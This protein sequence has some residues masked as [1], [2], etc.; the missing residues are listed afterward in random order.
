MG[1]LISD[2]KA[3]DVT[4]PAG[5]YSFGDLFRINGWTGI[6]MKS[7]AAADTDRKLAL[8]VSSER[9]WKVKIPAIAPAVGA[10]LYWTAGAGVKRGDTDLTLT[11]T[12]VPVAKCVEAINANGYA[13]VRV[14]QGV[15]V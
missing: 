8:E 3:I 7:I 11:P 15:V 6:A 12:D 2:G 14:L 13:T 5:V 4:A 9:F 10:M 1:H